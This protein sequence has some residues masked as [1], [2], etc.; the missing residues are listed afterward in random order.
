MKERK[1]EEGINIL[2]DHEHMEHMHT[3]ERRKRRRKRRNRLLE[4]R[5]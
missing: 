3:V 1:E 4:R 2:A 5:D